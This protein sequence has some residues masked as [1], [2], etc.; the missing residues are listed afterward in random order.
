MVWIPNRLQESS[1]ALKAQLHA[2][3]LEPI[4]IGNRLGISHENP[5]GVIRFGVA[6]RMG[7]Q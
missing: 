4:E 5:A 6:R 1:D 7:P 3:T 2:E